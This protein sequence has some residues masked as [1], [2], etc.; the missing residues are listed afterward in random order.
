M[1]LS[2]HE[3]AGIHLLALAVL[4]A[5]LTV[6]ACGYYSTSSR[7]AKD[8]KSV[9]VPFFVNLTTEP[10]LEITVTE[11]LINNLVADNTLKVTDEEYADAV[12]TGEIVEFINVPFSF[13]NELDAQEYNVV[14]KVK[15]SLFNRRKNEP[16]WS[17]MI[18]SGDG[19]YFVD[20]VDSVAQTFDGAV[21]ESI[22][23]ITERILNL[24]VQDW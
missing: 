21:V 16:I 1:K 12:L 6:G 5:S 10:D 18:I 19:S 7:T 4:T 22:R 9:A 23:E 20:A 17:D 8:I 24:T 14:I 2:R 15:V 3:S 13:D 11:R